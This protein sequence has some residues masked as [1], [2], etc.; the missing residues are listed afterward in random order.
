[1]RGLL[2]CGASPAWQNIIC[3]GVLFPLE[4]DPPSAGSFFFISLYMVLQPA[5]WH[6]ILYLLRDHASCPFRPRI[7]DVSGF[8]KYAGNPDIL[9]FHWILLSGIFS[10]SKMRTS[11]GKFYPHHAGWSEFL[12][13][14]VKRRYEKS[15]AIYPVILYRIHTATPFQLRK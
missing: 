8:G 3:S 4:A 2:S 1:M 7:H 11:G 6:C 12:R 15:G 13:A 14:S 10:G 9:R 5:F